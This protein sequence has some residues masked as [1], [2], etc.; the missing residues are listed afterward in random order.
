MLYID[1]Y[2]FKEKPF[3]ETAN[4]KFVWLGQKQLQILR[5]L[6]NGVQKNKGITLLTG[7]VGTGKTIL[8]NYLAESLRDQILVSR[9]NNPDLDISDF[10][11]SLSDSINLGASFEEQRY[12]RHVT[13]W[14]WRSVTIRGNQT[15]AHS[16]G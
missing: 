7:D 6:K 8:L 9:I 5:I 13:Q 4:P 1:H 2:G 11:N 15:T 16:G 14:G 3:Q 12:F 10:L